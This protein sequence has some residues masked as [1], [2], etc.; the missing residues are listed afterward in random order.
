MAPYSNETLLDHVDGLTNV[1][2]VVAVPW[3]PG[4]ADRWAARWDAHM[5]GQERT[6]P[7]PLINDPVVVQGLKT[8]TAIINLG[9]GLGQPS[10]NKMAEEI[11]RIL[12][13]KGH[14]DPSADIKS[15][16]IRHNWHPTAAGDL[17]TLARKIWSLKNKSS[18]AQIHDPDGRYARWKAE[19]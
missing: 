19:A 17:E 6:A 18:L 8:L 16:A 15:W 13:V 11:L 10:D 1:A 2:G 4:E 5:H 14:A 9:T 3:V 12:R 7:A